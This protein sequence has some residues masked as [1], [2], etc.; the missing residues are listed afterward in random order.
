MNFIAL[1][2]ITTLFI[3][4]VFHFYWAFGGT[5]GLDRAI[6]TKDGKALLNPGKL[7][8]II[9]GFIILYHHLLTHQY[10]GYT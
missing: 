1:V 10:L 4:G 7:L 2:T 6:P 3:A 5:L 8:T 9:V